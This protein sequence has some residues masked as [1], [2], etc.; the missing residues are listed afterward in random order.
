M[1]NE[2]KAVIDTSVFIAALKSKSDSS[3]PVKLVNS[4]HEGFFKI[5]TSPQILEELVR[6][7][8]EYNFNENMIAEFVSYIRANSIETTGLYTTNKL[9]NIDPKDNMILSTAYESKSDFIVTLDS[10][11][12]LPIKHYHG[13]QII[14]PSAFIREIENSKMTTRREIRT[15]IY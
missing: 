10:K 6:K 14:S 3:S 1:E 12:I 7:L 4:C 13:T 9:D 8:I 5:V 11:H 2:I 15:G